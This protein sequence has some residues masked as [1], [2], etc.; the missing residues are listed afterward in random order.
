MKK[1]TEDAAGHGVEGTFIL[2]GRG[3]GKP[4]PVAAGK[5]DPGPPGELEDPVNGFSGQKAEG[6]AWL[7][8]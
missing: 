7:C 2:R 6:G 1:S 3:F 4:S 5:T 8:L